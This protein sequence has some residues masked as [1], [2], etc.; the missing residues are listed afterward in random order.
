MAV[1]GKLWRMRVLKSCRFYS[2]EFHFK[3]SVNRTLKDPISNNGSRSKFQSLCKQTLESSN[4]ANFESF[5][6][7]LD[8]DSGHEKL[9]NW[10]KCWVSRK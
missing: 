7:K 5:F 4:K 3:Q 10:F 6:Q 2:C 8:K 9:K 1:T